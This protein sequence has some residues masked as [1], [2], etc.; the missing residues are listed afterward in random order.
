MAIKISSIKH[1]L[2]FILLF[3]LINNGVGQKAEV[4]L[5]PEAILIGEHAEFTLKVEAHVDER[6]I[7]P[8]FSD[9]IHNEI[10]I[11]RYGMIDTTY[12]DDNKHV[13]YTQ[14][15]IIT[16]FEE[17]YHPIKP[18]TFKS[19]INNDTLKFESEPLLLT[20]KSVD[21]DMEAA[22]KDIKPIIEIPRTFAE[23]LPYILI[24]L[25]IVVIVLFIVYY[26]KQRKKKP[27][28][29]SVWE[30]PDVPAYAAALSKLEALRKSN[31]LKEEK[32]KLF[33]SELTDILRRYIEKQFGINA[34]EMVSDEILSQTK[35]ALNVQE[36][37]KLKEILILSDLVKFA[38]HK[39]IVNESEQLLKYGFE[40]VKNTIPV[41][42]ENS[43]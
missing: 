18:V 33:H 9:T 24:V 3:S 8:L 43:K 32:F 4:L 5:E 35:K 39:P 27:A 20:V 41:D 10:E 25:L 21:V 34:P 15:Y 37:N 2:V 6:I 1:L 36:H 31:Y 19:V 30:R 22:P 11:L 23:M 12:T 26:L 42:E 29:Q 40:F 28:E 16:S 38:K 17:G 13:A 7:F 14:T